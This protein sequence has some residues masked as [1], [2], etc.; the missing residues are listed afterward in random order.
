MV[1]STWP[2]LARLRRPARRSPEQHTWPS[3]PWTCYGWEALVVASDSVTVSV[4]VVRVGTRD[5]DRPV[6]VLGTVA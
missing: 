1:S 4:Q 3:L 2:L 5:P 6:D